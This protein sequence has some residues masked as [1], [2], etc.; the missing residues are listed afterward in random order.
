[1]ND[2]EIEPEEFLQEIDANVNKLIANERI[3]LEKV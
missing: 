1:M 3:H 2:K